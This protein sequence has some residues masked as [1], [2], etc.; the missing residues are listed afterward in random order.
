MVLNDQKNPMPKVAR[1]D[2]EEVKVI[3]L[4]DMTNLH[5]ASS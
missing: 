1:A 5:F 2:S 3:Q 4:T